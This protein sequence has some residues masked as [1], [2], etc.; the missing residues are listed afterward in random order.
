MGVFGALKPLKKITVIQPYKLPANSLRWFAYKWHRAKELRSLH[1]GPTRYLGRIGKPDLNSEKHKSGERANDSISDEPVSRDALDIAV[2]EGSGDQ[3][4][5][6]YHRFLLGV[7]SSATVA[8]VL[9]AAHY[10]KRRSFDEG[11]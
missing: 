11:G 6:G 9:T 2:N 4:H 8:F 7:Q 3:G 1:V 10:A 5:N